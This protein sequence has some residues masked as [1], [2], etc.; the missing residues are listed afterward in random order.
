MAIM[1]A[2]D[3][4][5]SLIGRVYRSLLCGMKIKKRRVSSVPLKLKKRR[6]S[7]VPF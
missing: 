5:N 4:L 2:Q 1:Y 3:L 7:S 6:V